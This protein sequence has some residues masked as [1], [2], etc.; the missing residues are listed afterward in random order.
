MATE[1][2]NEAQSRCTDRRTVSAADLSG[3][4]QGFPRTH[5][6]P[7]GKLPGR[8]RAVSPSSWEFSSRTLEAASQTQ[9][10]DIWYVRRVGHYVLLS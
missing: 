8:L 7:P 9:Q 1:A 6:N 5:G 10:P 3:T 2:D 4:S